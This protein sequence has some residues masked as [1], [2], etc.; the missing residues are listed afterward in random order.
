MSSLIESLKNVEDCSD[1]ED[2]ENSKQDVVDI[3]NKFKYRCLGVKPNRPFLFAYSALIDDDV[4]KRTKKAG[5]DEVYL[6]P[7]HINLGYSIL[8]N[9]RSAVYE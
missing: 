7:I 4:R 1:E 3:Y 2:E 9:E 8:P 5:F 6:A